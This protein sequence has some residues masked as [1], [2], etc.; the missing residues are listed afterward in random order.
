MRSAPFWDI[1]QRRV[2]IVYRY[3]GTAFRSHL[4]ESRSPRRKIGLICCP[5]T[6][7]N[8]YHTA[9]HNIAEERT[10]H[11]WIYFFF[12]CTALQTGRPAGS[13]HDGVIGI[14][15]WHN[16]SGCT[17]ALGST[18][19][20]TEM[21]TRNICWGVKVAGASGWQPYHLHVP[22]VLKSGSLNLLE[23]PGPARACTGTALPCF[24]QQNAEASI[25][26][27]SFI[28]FFVTVGICYEWT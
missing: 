19:P 11:V 9:L 25:C 1:T 4:Q 17:M 28:I 21:S 20:L 5:E 12:C 13:I 18:Q 7:V 23:P 16:P 8:N 14:F 26:D 6:S 3:F 27:F 15:H 2:V 10:S 24:I 22:T